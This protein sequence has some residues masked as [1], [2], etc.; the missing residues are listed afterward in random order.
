MTFILVECME[1]CRVGGVRTGRT[2]VLVCAWIWMCS[3]QYEAVIPPW[4]A[5]QTHYNCDDGCAFIFVNWLYETLWCWVCTNSGFVCTGDACVWIWMCYFGLTQYYYE[6]VTSP[7]CA[8]QI[9]YNGDDGCAFTFVECMEVCQDH[10]IQTD[11]TFVLVCG[12]ICVIG[13]GCS[14]M[15]S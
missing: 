14:I 9:N 10:W 4:C 2:F 12:W 13:V 15:R 5:V 11:S 8:V 1:H 3:T 7:P 6:I